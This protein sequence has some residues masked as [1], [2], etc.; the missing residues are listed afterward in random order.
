M[1]NPIYRVAAVQFVNRLTVFSSPV[2][3]ISETMEGL[4]LEP[5]PNGVKV[6]KSGADGY[7]VIGWANIASVRYRSEP[8]N[9]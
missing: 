8:R 9:G 1:P 6:N 7:E 2:M 4:T 3:S 5:H